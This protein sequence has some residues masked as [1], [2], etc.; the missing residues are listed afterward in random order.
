M[1]RN[2]GSLLCVYGSVS[3]LQFGTQ[4]R[5]VARW[6]GTRLTALCVRQCGRVSAVLFGTQFRLLAAHSEV[7]SPRFFRGAIDGRFATF[8]R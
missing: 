8:A 4:R 3:C 5:E 1:L 7:T 2:F 6:C